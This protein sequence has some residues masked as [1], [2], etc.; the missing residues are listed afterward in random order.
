MKEYYTKEE[1]EKLGFTVGNQPP[2]TER[3]HLLLTK[4]EF[5]RIGGIFKYWFEQ[6]DFNKATNGVENNFEE[7]R[8]K[9]IKWTYDYLRQFWPNVQYKILDYKKSFELELKTVYNL[10]ELPIGMYDTVAFKFAKAR[11]ELFLLIGDYPTVMDECRFNAYDE[12]DGKF[13]RPNWNVF[14]GNKT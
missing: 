10:K 3:A 12:P 14:Q 13:V 6:P 11:P 9:F 2:K 5:E 7:T 8:A 1:G 4:N